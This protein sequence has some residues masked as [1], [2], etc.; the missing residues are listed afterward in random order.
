MENILLEEQAPN[1]TITSNNDD[2]EKMSDFL[3]ALGIS[4]NT[5]K[6]VFLF[7][8]GS[9]LMNK[10]DPMTKRSLISMYARLFDPMDFVSLFLIKP[11]RLFQELCA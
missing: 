4:W 10:I 3:K 5:N 6:D 8:T 11:K 7:K 2:S 1:F 9:A